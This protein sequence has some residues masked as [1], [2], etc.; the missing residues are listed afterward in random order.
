MLTKQD[1][2]SSLLLR[3]FTINMAIRQEYSVIASELLTRL[4]TIKGGRDTMAKPLRGRNR[5]VEV[6]G[7]TFPKISFVLQALNMPCQSLAQI[8][9]RYGSLNEYIRRY[10]PQSSEEEILKKLLNT[11][12]N[13]ISDPIKREVIEHL[14]TSI[15]EYIERHTELKSSNKVYAELVLL[16]HTQ[17]F[18]KDMRSALRRS[19]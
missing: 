12:E 5:Q 18:I 9:K 7:L 13:F 10:Y 4:S 2:T 14:Q 3:N 8:E 1:G 17:D 19:R 16:A 6:Y 15:R 11:P